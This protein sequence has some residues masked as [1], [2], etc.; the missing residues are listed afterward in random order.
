MRKLK[1]DPVKYKYINLILTQGSAKK[2]FRNLSHCGFF[3]HRYGS[4]DTPRRTWD[5][6]QCTAVLGPHTFT[7]VFM[8][9]G[10]TKLQP[11]PE[12]RPLPIS[13]LLW[14]WK[15]T[16]YS[17]FLGLRMQHSHPQ[18]PAEIYE[19]EIFWQNSFRGTFMTIN[20]RI[21]LHMR[22]RW[23]ANPWTKVPSL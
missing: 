14:T 23:F 7:V 4:Q 6:L 13:V 15:P 21:N 22:N 10:L 19:I 1:A 16:K 12:A 20:E 2:Q 18:T 3:F 5:V 9:R 11:A 17:Q 8:I